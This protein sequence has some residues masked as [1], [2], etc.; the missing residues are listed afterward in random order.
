MITGSG[1]ASAGFSMPRASSIVAGATT[2]MPGTCA[3][4]FSKLCECWAASWRP[5][6]VA[7]RIT[8]GMLNW[9]PDMCR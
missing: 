2:L 5:A 7:I 3:Y 9:P 8:S 1:S 4:Q 6:P